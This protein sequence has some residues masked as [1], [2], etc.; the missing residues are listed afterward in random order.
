MNFGTKITSWYIINKRTLPW[1]ETK[2]PYFIWLSEVLLQQTRVDQGIGYYLRFV[3]AFP[4]VD[5]LANAKEEEVLKLWQGLGYYSR[6]RNIHFAAKQVI[7]EFKGVFPN[8]YKDIIKLKGVGEYTAAAV[9]SICYEEEIAVVD[10]NVYRVLSRYLEI[11]TAIDTTVGKKEFK[12]IANELIKT[13]QPSVFN[14]GVMELGALICTPKK[15]KCDV[16]PIND[17]CVSFANKTLLSLPVKAKKTKQRNRYFNFIVIEN[18][19]K[20]YIQ[21]REGKGIWQNMYQFPLIETIEEMTEWNE[22]I[23]GITT[24][25]A[26][27]TIK[28][29]LSHQIIYARFWHAEINSSH[30]LPSDKWELL[31]LEKI[32]M[33]PLPKLIENYIMDENNFGA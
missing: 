32:K 7:N 24:P 17:S 30:F 23:K 18:D 4:T 21:K 31:T 2:N 12:S 11:E 6:A 10:G 14:Q 3:E 13:H 20:F 1:R 19:T 5:D 8:K 33:K 27:E 9:S 16:C 26:S 25:S 15:P 28:H 22:E 29:I